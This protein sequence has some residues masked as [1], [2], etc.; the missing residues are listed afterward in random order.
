MHKR[1]RAI[2]NALYNFSRVRTWVL[3]CRTL[4]ENANMGD[5]LTYNAPRRELNFL[6][7]WENLKRRTDHMTFT[8][9]LP[10][11]WIRIIE[12]CQSKWLKAGFQTTSSTS[13]RWTDSRL[14]WWPRWKLKGVPI[15]SMTVHEISSHTDFSFLESLVARIKVTVAGVTNTCLY[16]WCV[17]Q[18]Q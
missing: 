2:W 9:T 14:S 12:I 13:V 1:W 7:I 8:T 15:C 11:C 6:S 18:N 3:H 16:V 10:N 4:D 17:Y 5:L